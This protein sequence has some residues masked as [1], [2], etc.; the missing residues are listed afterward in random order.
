VVTRDAPPSQP[1]RQPASR[2][3]GR[4]AGHTLLLRWHS[5]RLRVPPLGGAS[6]TLSRFTLGLLDWVQYI[7]CTHAH[8]LF[9][10]PH[11]LCTHT[12]HGAD[13]TLADGSR[14]RRPQL[15]FEWR[16]T[17]YCRKLE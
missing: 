16:S 9:L 11:P 14:A 13:F 12:E 1:A 5:D 10:A 8:W 4:P 3:A 2:Q 7:I 17:Q 6:L 15:W